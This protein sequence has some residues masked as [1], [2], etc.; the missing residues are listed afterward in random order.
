M[1]KNL[2]LGTKIITGYLIMI[3][4]VAVTAVVGYNGIKTVAASLFQVGD[5]EAP[6]VDAAMEMKI[7][8]M[9]AMT[10]MDDFKTATAALATDNAEELDAIRTAYQEALNG[11]DAL[12]GAILNGATL[13]DGSVVLGTDN[14]SLK[15]LVS[16]SEKI[17]NEK[18]QAA[19]TEMM[20]RGQDLLAKKTARDAAMKSMESVFEELAAD[21]TAVEE[22]IAKEIR[23]RATAANV[24]AEAE[25]ILREEV[26]LADM[27]N[28][29]KFRSA[30]TRNVIEEYV[31]T[32]EATELDALEAEYQQMIAAFDLNAQ[33]ILEGAEVDGTTIVATDNADIRAAVQEMDENHA[34]FQEKV[35]EVMA[36]HRAMMTASEQAEA[37]MTRLDDSGTEAASKLDSVEEEAGGEM[38]TAKSLGVRAVSTSVTMMIVTAA[39]ALVMGL[40]LGVIL[41]RSISRPI[42]AIIKSMTEGSNQVA[43][44]SGQVA[45]SSQAMA[46]GASEQASSLEET[47]ASLEQL[48]SMTK[49]NATNAGQA[50]NLATNANTSADKGAQAMT[51]MSQAID[52]IKKSADATAKIVKTI[53]EIAFQ[54]NLLALNA[55]VEAARAGD[56]GKGFAVVAEEVRNLA[57][58]SAEAAKNTAAIIEDS[59]KKAENGVQI[60]RE[61]GEAL[62][63]ISETTRKVDALV[64]E[65]S[66][67]SNE[68]A[69]GIEQINTAVAQMDHVTQSNAA[70]SEESASA[71]EELSAQAEEMNRTVQQLAAVVGGASARSNGFSHAPAGP[72]QKSKLLRSS[73]GGPAVK[74]GTTDRRSRIP[75]L[76]VSGAATVRPEHVIPLDDEDLKEF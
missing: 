65:I 70:S 58:R 68:Q 2:A 17:H 13:S 66:S 1:F 54:T 22:M 40:L 52:D 14:E 76:A 46:E 57:Q 36:A 15:A 18:F 33:A 7:R 67:A 19:A 5:E 72:V 28:E 9:E 24:G 55:A 31:Q 38:A 11:F 35:T 75:A 8:M 30:A 3:V 61:V 26:P 23:T 42:N 69:Q 41:S 4:F 34:A 6:V 21:G 37:A 63:E 44:A 16:E 45:Q 53:D 12:A 60:S 71:S 32:V 29:M 50:K 49:Q 20:E 51:K 59:V 27:A 25:A 62:E 74:A 43:A 64:G 47:S 39:V 73:M 10:A 48:T 56:A